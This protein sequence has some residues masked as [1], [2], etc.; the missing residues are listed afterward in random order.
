MAKIGKA[1]FGP[2]QKAKKGLKMTIGQNKEGLNLGHNW[3]LKK[4]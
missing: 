4:D 3:F 1:E 2:K